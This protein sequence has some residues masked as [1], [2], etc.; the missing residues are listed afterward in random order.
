MR[1]GAG[2]SKDL[3]KQAEPEDDTSAPVLQEDSLG[4]RERLAQLPGLASLGGV[5]SG[6]G[7]LC[8]PERYL[9][10]LTPLS[11]SRMGPSY[12]VP[13]DVTDKVILEAGRY[14]K[15]TGALIRERQRHIWRSTKVKAVGTQ[16][17]GETEAER[18]RGRHVANKRETE[19]LPATLGT[20][21]GS[22]RVLD[23][24]C[25]LLGFGPL[26]SV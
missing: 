25:V 26:T 15:V 4:P 6:V 16:E 12:R 3:E 9:E 8:V 18:Q 1:G 20:G 2:S 10:V 21:R 11:I 14:G 22:H 24:A 5:A 7:G 13:A 17:A 23:G 19:E